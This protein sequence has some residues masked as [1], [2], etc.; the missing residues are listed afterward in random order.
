MCCTTVVSRTDAMLQL[1]R[2]SGWSRALRSPPT[3]ATSRKHAVRIVSLPVRWSTSSSPT[4]DTP[5]PSFAQSL[6]S[7]TVPI[8]ADQQRIPA[9]SSLSSRRN[10]RSRRR[11]PHERRTIDADSSTSEANRSVR[12]PRRPWRTRLQRK[13][14]TDQ[15]IRTVGR[16]KEVS[17][18]LTDG[19]SEYDPKEFDGKLNLHVLQAFRL[20]H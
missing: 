10:R 20:Q 8:V 6:S 13:N 1:L 14:R 2:S 3:A 7:L 16:K 17:T 11:G 5:S 4:D 18:A 15:A 12:G 19:T 9:H